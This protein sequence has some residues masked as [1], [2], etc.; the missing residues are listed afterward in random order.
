MNFFFN[1]IKTEKY[2]ELIKKVREKDDKFYLIKN[3]GSIVGNQSLFKYLK[4]FQLVIS[5]SKLKGDIIELGVWK[6]NN[7]IFIKKI[8]DYLKLKK[9]LYGYD[10]FEG[11]KEFEKLDNKINKRKYIGNKNKIKKLIKIQ[12]LKNIFL[13]DDDVKNFENHFNQNKKFCLIY[14]DLDLYRPTKNILNLI[15]SYLVKNGLIIFDQ[16]QKK[17]G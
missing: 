16:A 13:I 9:K 12:K 14:L 7:L 17:N 3:F 10:W 2:F 6:G 1:L 11:L 4:V 15:D 8:L 5:V